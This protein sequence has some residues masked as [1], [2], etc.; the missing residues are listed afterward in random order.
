MYTHIHLHCTGAGATSYWPFSL[1][2]SDQNV[3]KVLSN[4]LNKHIGT[5]VRSDQTRFILER[6]SFSNTCR[7]FNT[8]YSNRSPCSAVVSLDAQQAF[9]NGGASSLLLKD[10][11]Q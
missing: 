11:F 6:L 8:I 7:L 1:W 3:P 10:W 9:E 2:N 5:L 4:Q